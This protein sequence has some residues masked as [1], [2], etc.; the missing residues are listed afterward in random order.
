MDLEDAGSNAR[1]LIRDRDAK[2]TAAFDAVVADAGL[3]V[4]KSGVRMPRMNS[5]PNAGYPRAG[6]SCWTTPSS[7]TSATSST[8][9]ASSR[10]SM[11][12]TGLT[13]PSAAQPR[14]IGSPTI[15]DPDQITRLDVLRQGRLGGTLHKYRHAA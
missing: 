8:P 7:G 14:F 4:V 2:F 13:G 12:G 6:A 11:T 3:A 10:R 1:F 9:C 5:T 15:T